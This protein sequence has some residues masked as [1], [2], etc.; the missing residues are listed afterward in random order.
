MSAESNAAGG[1]NPHD[2]PNWLDVEGTVDYLRDEL[3]HYPGL[4]FLTLA[5]LSHMSP[6]LQS[7]YDLCLTTD[8]TRHT[9]DELEHHMTA[10]T[11]T[12]LGRLDALV[13]CNSPFNIVS[14]DPKTG[15]VGVLVPAENDMWSHPSLERCDAAGRPLFVW[16]EGM[17]G[18]EHY[19]EWNER[20][21]EMAG[22]VLE[23]LIEQ[24]SPSDSAELEYNESLLDAIH[25]VHGQMVREA[26][27]VR[28][29]GPML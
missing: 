15:C 23:D 27:Q 10:L 3:A 4:G 6:A 16:R 5:Q 24:D 28:M 14:H 29:N 12:D 22:R 7:A 17:W 20:V 9:D 26:V 1:P 21:N 11:P 18:Y 13:H 8:I 2:V 25:E 19:K